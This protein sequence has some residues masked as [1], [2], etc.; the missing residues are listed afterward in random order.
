MVLVLRKRDV[1]DYLAGPFLRVVGFVIFA[2]GFLWLSV[3]HVFDRKT[4]IEE[5]GLIP[6][7][8]DGNF[9]FY[10]N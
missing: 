5:H 3:F 10:K 6:G 7:F 1:V 4:E 9:F 8:A 2:V